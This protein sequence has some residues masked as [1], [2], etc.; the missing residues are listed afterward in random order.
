MVQYKSVQFSFECLENQ[1]MLRSRGWI[2]LLI[3]Y[4]VASI[5]AKEEANNSW[6][7]ENVELE[8]KKW[9]KGVK[10]SK[11]FSTE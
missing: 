4:L 1:N 8:L 3:C 11:D 5:F 2:F 9:L 7:K 10:T 6:N